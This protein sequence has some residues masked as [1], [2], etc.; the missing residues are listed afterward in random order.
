MYSICLHIF[1]FFFLQ[2]NMC[3]KMCEQNVLAFLVY[4]FLHVSP[5][6]I[7]RNSSSLT[8]GEKNK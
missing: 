5:V 3:P 7:A 6:I 8:T 1:V 2:K 4:I